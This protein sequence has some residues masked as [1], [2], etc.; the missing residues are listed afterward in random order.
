MRSVLLA[1]LV[2]LACHAAA[3]AADYVYG[4]PHDRTPTLQD[5]STTSQRPVAQEGEILV[6]VSSSTQQ[7]FRALAAQT[8]P[9]E[10][11]RVLADKAKSIRSILKLPNAA[12]TNKRA[13]TASKAATSREWLSIALTDESATIEACKLLQSSG[14]V[15]ACQRNLRHY[16]NTIPNDPLTT[17]NGLTLGNCAF[18]QR[19]SNL[20][21][22]EMI[23]AFEAWNSP[24][25]PTGGCQG[26]GV[27]VGVV[28]SGIDFTHP[29]IISSLYVNPDED[30]NQ[31]GVFD[32]FPADQG[33]DLDGIDGGGNTLVDDVVGANFVS[34]SLPPY[35]ELGHGTHCAGTIGATA[36]NGIGIAGI[37]PRAKILTAKSIGKQ[38]Y[39]T[40][41]WLAQGLRY[42]VDTVDRDR[43]GRVDRPTVIN[44]SWGSS[45]DEQD[46]ILEDAT[47]YAIAKGAV[48]VFAAGNSQMDASKVSP[49]SLPQAVMVSAVSPTRALSSFSNFGDRVAVSAPGGGGPAVRCSDPLQNISEDHYNVLSLL[50]TNSVFS[51]QQPTLVVGERYI[52]LAGTSMAAPHVVGVVALLLSQRP[53]LTPAQV[54]SMLLAGTVPSEESPY[55]YHTGTGIIDAVKTLSLPETVNVNGSFERWN[56]EINS[57]QTDYSVNGETFAAKTEIFL[58]KRDRYQIVDRQLLNT[59]LGRSKGTLAV[60]N[61]RAFSPQDELWI[62][63]KMSSSDYSATTRRRLYFDPSLRPGYPKQVSNTLNL[64]YGWYLLGQTAPIIADL[65]GNGENKLILKNPF[66]MWYSGF[67]IADK[68]GT[69]L[70]DVRPGGAS[71]IGSLYVADLTQDGRKQILSLGPVNKVYSSDGDLITERS[72]WAWKE[73][74]DYT[75]YRGFE[76]IASIGFVG[77]SQQPVIAQRGEVVRFY[78]SLKEPKTSTGSSYINLLDADL[79]DLP[80]WEGGKE[81]AANDGL[82][83]QPLIGDLNGDGL[84]EVI[85]GPT[86]QGY[87]YLFGLDG[88]ILSQRKV[89]INGSATGAVALADL[90]NDNVNELVYSAGDTLHAVNADGRE[91]TAWPVKIPSFWTS[92]PTFID[93]FSIADLNGD[94]YPEVVGAGRGRNSLFAIQYDGTDLP[95]WSKPLGDLFINHRPVIGQIDGSGQQNVAF[96]DPLRQSVNVIN[97]SGATVKEMMKRLIRGYQTMPVLADV[98]NDGGNEIVAVDE[99]GALFI[100]DT[101]GSSCDVNEWPTWGGDVYQSNVYSTP[102]KAQYIFGCGATIEVRIVDADA[103]PISGVLVNG[104][105]LGK[106]TSDAH[107]IVRFGG[108]PLGLSYELSFAHSIWKVSSLKGVVRGDESQSVYG[109]APPVTITGRVI[110]SLGRAV[111]GAVISGG[112]C[113][114][115]SSTSNGYF[116]LPGVRYGARCVITATHQGVTFSASQALGP[117]GF[118]NDLTL[119]GT[120]NKYPLIGRIVL[121]KKPVS[122]ALVRSSTGEVMRSSRAG[123]FKL[124][125]IEYGTRIDLTIS[126]RGYKTTRTSIVVDGSRRIAVNIRER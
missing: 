86:N 18:D 89:D 91:L 21:G 33:G 83:L 43:D 90:N 123:Y 92:L 69:I 9:E 2:S 67:R 107:G 59:V 79:R 125:D 47:N 24:G 58:M 52:R 34:R 77:S 71:G 80:G 122:G 4:K 113:G 101:K 110:D 74:A 57:G 63:M 98:D 48:V 109:S 117:L 6:R 22:H 7:G 41:E 16:T 119:I 97:S 54:K 124:R 120:R 8:S 118:G 95:G 45:S 25:C 121:K 78:P 30:R 106:R 84:N 72:A 87:L 55:Y 1:T 70:R 85:V 23:R 13:F 29:D 51:K 5:P 15:D 73:T 35:D 53:H 75:E 49:N 105:A 112:V 26:Q 126:G 116:T 39:G 61:P 111:V 50:S 31:N 14:V 64:G 100:W 114:T 104:G 42:I 19:I 115:T 27:V 102:R 44:N 28:D 60:I 82:N 3:Q 99:H 20:W 17:E 46:L 11:K 12:A 103:Q 38:G 36:G 81:L 108:L 32:P 37:A 66:N 62:E 88:A 93:T 65:T 68:S 96:R 56:Y 76:D 10:I 94:G 40:S